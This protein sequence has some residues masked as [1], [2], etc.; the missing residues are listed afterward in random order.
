[1]P[2]GLRE[3][4]CGESADVVSKDTVTTGSQPFHASEHKGG[5]LLGT[6]IWRGLSRALWAALSCPW[7][8]FTPCRSPP[9]DPQVTPSM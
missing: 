4:Q 2:A 7:A 3:T 5:F 6:S 9:G 1:M 8:Q